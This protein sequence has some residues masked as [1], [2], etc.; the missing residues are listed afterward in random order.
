MSA[1]IRQLT[2]A[3]AA[4]YQSLRL[5]GLQDSPSSFSASYADEAGRALGEVEARLSPVADGSRC[6]FGALESGSLA[7]ILAFVRPERDKLRHWAELAGLYVVPESRRRGIGGALIDAAISHARLLPGLRQ[8]KLGV[9][10]DNLAAR[11]LYVSRGF[12]CVGVHPESLFV[13]GRFY[14]EELYV[15]PLSRET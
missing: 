12:R 2:P 11:L 8:L 9:N 6:V 4:A 1:L 3:D 14:D 13:D 7:G 15:L 10:A 5:R